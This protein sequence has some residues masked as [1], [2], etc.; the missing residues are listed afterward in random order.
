M[1][2]ILSGQS[3]DI[4]LFSNYFFWESPKNC[5]KKYCECKDY[6]QAYKKKHITLTK[7]VVK[8]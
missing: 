6:T 8:H 2:I 7:S 1:I 3:Q 5:E 4:P